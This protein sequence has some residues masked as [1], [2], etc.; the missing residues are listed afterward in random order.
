MVVLGKTGLLVSDFTGWRW[1]WQAS[2]QDIVPG[3]LI[4]GVWGPRRAPAAPG[5]WPYSPCP[6]P[7]A[8]QLLRMKIET[9]EKLVKLKDAQIRSL[10]HKL[11]V[12][13]LARADEPWATQP[14]PESTLCA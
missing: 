1:I 8:L 5:S 6:D 4:I 2:G 13:G 9:L 7:L 10:A 3:P 12:S 11:A 14:G